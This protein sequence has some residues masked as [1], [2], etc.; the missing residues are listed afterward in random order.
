[1]K[2]IPE[3]YRIYHRSSPN[4]K[5]GMPYYVDEFVDGRWVSQH[6]AGVLIP[7]D[8]FIPANIMEISDEDNTN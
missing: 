1:M 5:P 7:Q 4:W 8:P 6:Y 3:Q 2:T